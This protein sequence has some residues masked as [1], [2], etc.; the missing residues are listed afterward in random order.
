MWCTYD[1]SIKSLDRSTRLIVWLVLGLSVIWVDGCKRSNSSVAV[2]TAGD[3]SSNTSDSRAPSRVGE[4]CTNSIGMKLTYIPPGVFVMGS[5][6]SEPGRADSLEPQH[7]VTLTRGFL[8]AT[9]PVT[10][11]QW[12]SI[13]P[14][15]QSYFHGLDLPAEDVSWDE[16]A[17]FCK[18]LSDKEGRHYRLPTEAEWEYA[19]RAG[20]TTTYNTGDGEQALGESGWFANNSGDKLIDSENIIRTGGDLFWLEKNN[21]RTHP[22]GQKKPNAW[23][24]YDMHGNVWEWCQDFF[25]GYPTDA[26]T[27]PQG[28]NSGGQSPTRVLRGGAWNSEARMCRSAHRNLEEPSRPKSAAGLRPVQ[29]LLP[30]VGAR[31]SGQASIAHAPALIPLFVV[32]APAL[33]VPAGWILNRGVKLDSL[34][35]EAI[36]VAS[37]VREHGVIDHGNSSFVPLWDSG[38]AVVEMRD[39]THNVYGEPVNDADKL[40]G[41]AARFEVGDV[42]QVYRIWHETGNSALGTQP[43]WSEW[44]TGSAGGFDDHLTN[45]NGKWQQD[46]YGIFAENLDEKH[47]VVLNAFAW[48]MVDPN[49]PVSGV[50]LSLA[51]E[52]ADKANKLTNGESPL[53]LDT[54]ARVYA[55]QGKF[56]SAVDTEQKA[57]GETTDGHRRN[58]FADTLLKY[59]NKAAQK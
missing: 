37:Q 14:D 31:Q 43:G 36:K 52:A 7:I 51:E 25:D 2:N 21:C 58:E 40:N 41:L 11:A 8:M 55:S 46:V 13:M 38:P 24:L 49:H 29:D 54:L 33:Q 30:P 3:S 56:D 59:K 48:W 39:V 27:D 45:R 53:I 50:D 17:L 16:A 9:T 4:S 18:K 20:T 10:Q 12:Q 35:A 22:V 34:T 42:Y 15:N 19:C 47:A 5:P 57:I 1:E 44:K 32:P 6:K 28:P 26:V 23:G